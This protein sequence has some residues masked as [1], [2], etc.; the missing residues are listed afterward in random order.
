MVCKRVAS[1]GWSVYGAPALVER[2]QPPRWERLPWIGYSSRA[3]FVPA[4]DWLDAL[5]SAPRPV[6]IAS[7]LLTVLSAVERG[8]GVGIVPDMMVRGRAL[9]ALTEP[10]E[11]VDV[12]L[13]VHPRSR[14]E[15]MI[16]R[17]RQE[18]ERIVSSWP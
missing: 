13:A 4:R 15:P 12:W 6:L 17:L 3:P 11:R 18:L 16:G 9:V 10:V 5:P 8:L 2:G 14:D 7:S 1:L